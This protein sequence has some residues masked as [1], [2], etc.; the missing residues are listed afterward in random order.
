MILA[1]DFNDVPDSPAMK[2]FGEGWIA[3]PKAGNPFTIPAPEPKREIDHV[4]L[5][6]LKAASPAAVLPEKVASD[7]RP[8][9]ATV[10]LP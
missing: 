2:V 3:V 5:R 7:H 10:A 8:L 9:V 6:G 1:G 4:L